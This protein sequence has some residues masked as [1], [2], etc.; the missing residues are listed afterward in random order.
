VKGEATPRIT[1]ENALN[2]LR[3]IWQIQDALGFE[4]TI[5]NSATMR[6]AA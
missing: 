3:V 6:V 5:Q 2:A 4:R 1:G